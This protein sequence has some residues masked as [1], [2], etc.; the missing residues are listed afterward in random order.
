MEDARDRLEAVGDA[1]PGPGDGLDRHDPQASLLDGLEVAGGRVLPQIAEGDPAVRGGEV[2]ARVQAGKVG[3]GKR[4]RTWALSRHAL[5]FRLDDEIAQQGALRDGDEESRVDEDGDG[6]DTGQSL[7]DGVDLALD[8]AH[9]PAR[10]GSIADEEPDVD[11]AQLDIVDGRIRLDVDGGARL[12]ACAGELELVDAGGGDDEVGLEGDDG[13]DVHQARP[14][15]HDLCLWG[16]A[17]AKP[18]WNAHE[19]VASADLEEDPGRA[20]VE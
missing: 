16:L 13:V 20:R 1:R 19:S 7:L 14:S 18:G 3:E 11:G 4:A 5:T 9:E 2:D 8:A 17:T 6:L 15:H 10:A 12:P